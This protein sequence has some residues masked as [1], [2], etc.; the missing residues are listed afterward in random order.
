MGVRFYGQTPIKLENSHDSVADR[1][2][3]FPGA[4]FATRNIHWSWQFRAFIIALL[5]VQ[6]VIAPL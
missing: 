6:T 2:F 5:G 3:R 1:G 4:N